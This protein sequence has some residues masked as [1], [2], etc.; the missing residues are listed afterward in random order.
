[1]VDKGGSLVVQ[2]APNGLYNTSN[3]G[4]GAN[5]E[6]RRCL[7]CPGSR[8]PPSNSF[9][10]RLA[11]TFSPVRSSTGSR[12]GS[13]ISRVSGR[14]VSARN[15]EEGATLGDQHRI[16]MTSKRWQR[17]QGSTLVFSSST[18]SVEWLCQRTKGLYLRQNT[19]LGD[20]LTRCPKYG[21][22]LKMWFLV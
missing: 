19:D 15:N 7:R 16:I 12:P 4:W 8:Y 21:C 11:Q 10:L 3:N 1:M 5:K 18:G 13:V 6:Q 22:N 17:K 9:S 14:L 2:G 20:S